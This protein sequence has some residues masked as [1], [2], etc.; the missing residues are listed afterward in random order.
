V[1]K[2]KSHSNFINQIKKESILS[3]CCSRDSTESI[4]IVLEAL[5]NQA[6][7]VINTID[8]F[9]ST[10][11]ITAC[12]YGL[13]DNAM[14]L[15]EAKADVNLQDSNKNTALLAV[16]KRSD[17]ENGLR[18]I[19]LLISK[20]ANIHLRN[21]YNHSPLK[22]ACCINNVSLVDY[23]L[24]NKAD[25]NDRGGGDSFET[26]L[27]MCAI[28]YTGDNSLELLELLLLRN[29][30]VNLPD[31]KGATVLM[32][33]CRN[34]CVEEIKMFLKFKGDFDINYTDKMGHT[35]LMHAC[36]K[37]I[38]T[39]KYNTIIELLLE[40]NADASIISDKT[41]DSA[42]SLVKSHEGKIAISEAIASH[43]ISYVLK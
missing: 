31:N 24:T 7:S 8:I 25:V 37:F 17:G 30:D 38:D 6:E 27:Y 9:K 18:F 33:C 28:A 10:C 12:S 40:S 20:D 35:A 41:G 2:L 39:L 14:M 16:C 26:P 23:L 19:E 42:S 5:G 36:V 21:K 1:K 22:C 29:A 3:Y 11:L 4:Q 13:Y 34:G 32:M 15:L 43:D